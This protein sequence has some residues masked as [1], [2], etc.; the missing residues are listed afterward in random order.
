MARQTREG[1]RISE[2]LLDELLAGED[3][4]EVLRYGGLIADLKKAVAE[5][6]LDAEMDAH[7]ERGQEQT[8]AITAMVTTE[9]AC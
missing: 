7:L 1:R 9:S 6:A 8:W 3:P 2:E 5:R 4:G